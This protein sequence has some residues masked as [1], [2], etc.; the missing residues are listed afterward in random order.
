MTWVLWILAL[1][2]VWAQ[3]LPPG[4][5]RN[6]KPTKYLILEKGQLRLCLFALR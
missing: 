2:N 4:T 5:Y 6:L 1:G 3:P